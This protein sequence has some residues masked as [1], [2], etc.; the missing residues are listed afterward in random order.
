MAG[1]QQEHSFKHRIL[2][3]NVGNCGG[4]PLNEIKIGLYEYGGGAENHVGFRY[5]ARVVY[6]LRQREEARRGLY[7]LRLLGKIAYDELEL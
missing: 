3:A 2:R 7:E 1:A 6:F 4:E 5:H